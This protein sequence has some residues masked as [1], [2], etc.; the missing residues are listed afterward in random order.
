MPVYTI[1]NTNIKYKLK[2]RDDIKRRYIQVTPSQ[3]LVTVRLEDSLVEITG[4]LK[5]K[6]RWLFDS[7]QKIKEAVAK[8]HTIHQFTSGIKIPYRGRRVALTV[9]RKKSPSIEIEFKGGIRV[10]VPDY[11]K[12]K[13]QDEVIE[14]ALRLWL[15][16]QARKD[17]DLIAKRY[18]EQ[19]GL[20]LKAVRVKD[21]KH[22]WGSCSKDGTLHL[23]WRLIHAP[24]AVLEYAVVHELCHLRHRTHGAAFWRFLKS[25]LP[26][27]EKAKLWLDKNEHLLGYELHG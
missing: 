25:V 6:E 18:A 15:K 14:D 27:Y 10:M 7:T 11:I 3:V 23:N 13:E 2:R 9:S 16:K 24:K 8:R 12:T 17:I 20:R 22:M 5:R 21:Q 19:Y 1:G 4:F 26:E